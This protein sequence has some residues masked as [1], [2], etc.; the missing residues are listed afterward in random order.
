MTDPNDELPIDPL[1]ADALSEL[2]GARTHECLPEA[3]DQANRI[4]VWM[5]EQGIKPGFANTL[6]LLTLA[7][8]NARLRRATCGIL[9]LLV[10]MV[11]ELLETGVISS[12]EPPSSTEPK[13]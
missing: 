7:A 3:L 11:W 2:L 9:E 5:N 1:T 4:A 12:I 13:S 6:A 8:G 10:G